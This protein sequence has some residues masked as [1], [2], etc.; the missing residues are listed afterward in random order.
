M[1]DSARAGQGDVTRA[2]SRANGQTRI[3]STDGVPVRERF[4]YWREVVCNATTGFFGPPTTAPP[5]VF[6]ARVAMRSCGPLRFMLGES[7]TNYQIA[8][9]RRDAANAPS[10]YYAIYLQLSGESMSIRGEEAITLRAGDTG[11]CLGGPYL[12]EHG[13]RSAIARAPGP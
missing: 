11:F 8:L 3:W 12:G 5:G 10:D 9:T 6:S 7:E 1:V 4:S 13:C 2:V